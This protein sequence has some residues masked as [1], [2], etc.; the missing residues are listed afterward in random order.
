MPVGIFHLTFCQNNQSELN[1]TVS[2]IQ[3]RENIFIY[4]PSLV[5]GVYSYYVAKLCMEVLVI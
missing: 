2:V 4:L 5:K 3:E 1:L